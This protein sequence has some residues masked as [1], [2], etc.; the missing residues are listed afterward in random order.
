MRR[1]AGV[2][3]IHYFHRVDDPY[4][5]LMVQVIPELMERF[6]VKVVP[7][8]VERLDARMYPDPV[9]FEAMAIIDAGRL[10]ALYGLGFPRDAIVPDRLSVGMAARHLASIE[11]DP[12]F[13]E[14]AESTGEALWRYDMRKVR[15]MA[16]MADMSDEHL[17]ANERL[18]RRLGHWASGTLIYEGEAYPGLDRIE[19]LEARLNEEDAGDGQVHFDLMRRWR[20]RQI[21]EGK[22][23]PIGGQ[24][25]LF[26]SL[27]SP[28]SYL[29]IEQVMR[30]SA[31]SGVRF[32][33]RPI[34][35]MVTRGLPVPKM[36]RDYIVFD[37]AR[38]ARALEIPFGQIA[39][40][41]GEAVTKALSF[42]FALADDG[43]DQAF[44]RAWMQSTWALGNN[45]LSAA[46]M[47]H[48]LKRIGVKP[49]D[50]KPL[51]ES[52]WRPV[53]E[54]NLR[55]MMAS[56]SWGVPTFRVG[57]QTFW[58]QDR[59]WAVVGSLTNI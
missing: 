33:L 38:E 29:A 51:N 48:I 46:G 4:C 50:I 40:P 9:R 43:N 25:D 18:L 17:R 57:E 35:P 47:D 45:G 20:S 39:D 26:F 23:T 19:H 8:V 3:E 2:R 7:H 14:A 24:A 32:N 36:K 58:G 6:E 5:Q 49:Q 44:Y 15:S 16:G 42:G 34:L 28:Y 53:V 12:S 30:L 59:V 37:A 55:D 22:Q 41:L 54:N 11:N 31:R 1:R 21:T 27:R 10:A 13:F 56:G 52:A